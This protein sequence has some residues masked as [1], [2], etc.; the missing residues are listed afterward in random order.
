ML[1][2]GRRL[3]F[4]LQL[5]KKLSLVKG[6]KKNGPQ[7]RVQLWEEDWLLLSLN[8]LGSHVVKCKRALQAIRQVLLVVSCVASK[9]CLLVLNNFVSQQKGQKEI[10]AQNLIFCV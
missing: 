6:G 1:A 10:E 2:G 4:V 8:A 9:A 3:G 5:S 7:L